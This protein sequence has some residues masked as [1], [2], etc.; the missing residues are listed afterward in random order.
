MALSK[1]VRRLW[2]DEELRACVRAYF[3]LQILAFPITADFVR[4]RERMMENCLK[5]RSDR[6]YDL[7]MKNISHV[8]GEIGY[9]TL[10]Y[11]VAAPH[12]GRNITQR[13]QGIIAEIYGPRFDPLAYSEDFLKEVHEASNSIKRGQV[14]LVRGTRVPPRRTLYVTERFSR[15]P[16]VVAHVL[17]R[18][19]G[20]CEACQKRGPFRAMRDQQPF[21][22]V[23]HVLP[24][25]AGGPDTRD[26]ATAVCP[27]CHRRLHYSSDKD[28]YRARLIGQVEELFDHEGAAPE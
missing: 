23:H 3:E 8:L 11:Y 18:A 14:P 6:S 21:L 10:D 16:F 22:E 2:S 7:R 5:Q 15:D 1:D 25:S 19:D 24:L 4:V 20:V 13:L 26:N 28:E 12:V 17:M 27:N 9:P